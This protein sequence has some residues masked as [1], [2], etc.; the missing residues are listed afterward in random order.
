MNQDHNHFHTKSTFTKA[1][2]KD[3]D[4]DVFNEY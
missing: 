1:L 3:K 4:Y 2:H